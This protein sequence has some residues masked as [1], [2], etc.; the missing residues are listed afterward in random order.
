MCPPNRKSNRERLGGSPL[1]CGMES[2]AY[3]LQRAEGE[4][5]ELLHKKG[6][7]NGCLFYGVNT[8]SAWEICARTSR[9]LLFV[10]SL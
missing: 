1:R 2:M 7:R 8:P 9:F 6:T 10:R 3:V 4:A 5:P